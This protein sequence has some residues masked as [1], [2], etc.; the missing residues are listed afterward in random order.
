MIH[1]KLELILTEKLIV[2]IAV[3]FVLHAVL[4]LDLAR[5]ASLEIRSIM[6]LA[7]LALLTLIMKMDRVSV[8]HAILAWIVIVLLEL[9][10]N[11][12][13]DMV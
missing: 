5:V 6:E 8:Q 4:R 3:L 11:V 1:A 7:L 13:M 2:K 9:A 12:L 10:L